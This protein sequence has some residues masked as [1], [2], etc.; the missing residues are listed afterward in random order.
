MTLQQLC[1]YCDNHPDLHEEIRP[2]VWEWWNEK[3]SISVGM[4]EIIISDSFI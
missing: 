1:D 3:S 2:N 4:N